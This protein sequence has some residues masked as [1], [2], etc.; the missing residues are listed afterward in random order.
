MKIKSLNVYVIIHQHTTDTAISN[1]QQPKNVFKP[2]M[3]LKVILF[4]FY[5]Q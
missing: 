5:Y 4:T 2:N 3:F 1:S